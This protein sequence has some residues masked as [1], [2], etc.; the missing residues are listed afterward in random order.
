MGWG[1]VVVERGLLEERAGLR[2]AALQL[3]A[4]PRSK[5]THTKV[6]LLGS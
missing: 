2:T 5:L 1:G 4:N 3:V 6:Q